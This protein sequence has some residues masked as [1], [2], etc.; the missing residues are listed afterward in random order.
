[1][2]KFVLNDGDR[3]AP[4]VIEVERIGTLIGLEVAY[5]DDA[6]NRSHEDYGYANLNKY[7]ALQV[8]AALYS[9]AGELVPVQPVEKKPDGYIV[10]RNGIEDSTFTPSKT[11]NQMTK[12]P[13]Y[14]THLED[15]K[16]SASEWA[17][18]LKA[19][20]TVYAVTE[21]GTA[22]PPAMPATVWMEK[23]S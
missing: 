23:Q 22:A 6:G 3:F 13:N 1:M 10:R 4:A 19:P 8:A 14:F 15:A 21:I 18:R 17:T 16:K 11:N 5:V 12:A 2:S 7:Q 20:F 9:A